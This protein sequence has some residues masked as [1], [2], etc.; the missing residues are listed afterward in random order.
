M[1]NPDADFYYPEDPPHQYRHHA[2]VAPEALHTPVGALV[3]ARKFAPFE[4]Q[5]AVP[6][7][8]MV[9]F[10]QWMSRDILNLNIPAPGP[11]RQRL[12]SALDIVRVALAVELNALAGPSGTTLYRRA[13]HKPE[14][15]LKELATG[16]RRQLRIC[17]Y[18]S[19][20][21]NAPGLHPTILALWDGE[22]LE[23][24]AH[25]NP[26][27]AED[28]KW[29]PPVHVSLDISYLAW[30]VFNRLGIGSEL[31]RIIGQ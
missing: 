18:R 2:P 9:N 7:L 13:D 8:D 24:Y 21:P 29:P 15:Y 17:V 11:G 5:R 23:E 14:T 4:V 31:A 20:S 12:Y 30:E 27:I 16:T 10:R 3:F 26:W 6:E 19:P 22:T 25:H 1:A 28:T